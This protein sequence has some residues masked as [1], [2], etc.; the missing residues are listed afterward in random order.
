MPVAGANN[1]GE[2]WNLLKSAGNSECWSGPLGGGWRRGGPGRGLLEQV[3]EFD[4][5]VF[6][7]SSAEA[8]LMDPQQR[9]LLELAWEAA[10]D[11]II[12]IIDR[13]IPRPG[14]SRRRWPRITPSWCG[15]AG[16]R[17]SPGTPSPARVAVRSPIVSS[18]PSACAV[19]L[20]AVCGFDGG[21]ASKRAIQGIRV[22]VQV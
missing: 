10:E 12:P 6:G 2:F 8:R 13:R 7:I 11:A 17:R 20:P 9:L 1:P 16:K 18:A 5:A 15:T 3:D 14:P 21:S 4:A 19:P 22:G